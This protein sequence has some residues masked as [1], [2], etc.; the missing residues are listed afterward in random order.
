MQKENRFVALY[1]LLLAFAVVCFLC[2][3]SDAKTYNTTENY[4]LP[5]GL[6]DCK[7]FY[8]RGKGMA[9]NVMVVRCPDSETASHYKTSTC[10][11][12]T[13]ICTETYHRAVVTE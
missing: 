2:G 10:D 12:N 5:E 13:N 8:M 6:K 4:E 11:P 7:V 9:D 3:C 1:L